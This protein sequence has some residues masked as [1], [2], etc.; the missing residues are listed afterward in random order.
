MTGG[1][2]VEGSRVPLCNRL[3]PQGPRPCCGISGKYLNSSV[4]RF[5]LRNDVAET[6]LLHGCV[7]DQTGRRVGSGVP[8][9]VMHGAATSSS[10]QRFASGA[11]SKSAKGRGPKKSPSL[12][13]LEFSRCGRS[14]VSARHHWVTEGPRCEESA[15]HRWLW[16]AAGAQAAVNR[17]RCAPSGSRGGSGVW[18]RREGRPVTV[19]ECGCRARSRRP[20]VSPCVFTSSVM[21]AAVLCL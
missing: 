8:G 14:P 9:L 18:G 12:S 1:G 3:E 16:S 13:C 6:L 7:K 19:G 4:P 20:A 11:H 5:P 15:R 21:T 17:E 10:R 2:G